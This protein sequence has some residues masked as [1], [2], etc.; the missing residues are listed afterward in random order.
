MSGWDYE[1][2]LKEQMEKIEKLKEQGATIREILDKNIFCFEAMKRCNL[3]ISYLEPK[4]KGEEMDLQEW[5]THTSCEH[6]WEYYEGSPFGNPDERDRVLI[7]L[8]Y[9]C[10]F[11]HLLEIL[12]QA[13][14]EELFK[15]VSE[16]KHKK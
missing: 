13:S 14:K 1:G 7:G 4:A 6:K 11:S 9:T 15:V 12:P 2:Y 5:D 8:L 3:P 16:Y 10:G